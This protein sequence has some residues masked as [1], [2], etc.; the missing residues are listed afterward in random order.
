MHVLVASY[1]CLDQRLNL[2]PRYETMLKP[3]S[4]LAAAIH[5]VLQSHHAAGQHFPPALLIAG[6]TC[7]IWTCYLLRPLTDKLIQMPLTSPQVEPE[8]RAVIQWIRSLNFVLSANLHGGAVVANYPYDKSL[9]HRF[10]GYRRTANTPTPDDKLFQKVWTAARPAG[11]VGLRRVTQ[12]PAR[13]RPQ[14]RADS[15]ACSPGA[16]SLGNCLWF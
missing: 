7:L 2:Q 16:Y 3:M 10:R 14:E 8:T 11:N 6:R 4:D 13:Y 9:E 12:D 15:T 1:V 5:F